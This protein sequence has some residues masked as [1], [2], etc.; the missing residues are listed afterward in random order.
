MALAAGDR[1]GPYEILAPLAVEGAGEVYRAHDTLRGREFAIKIS[2]ERF[3]EPFERQARAAA[4]LDHPHICAL[5]DVGPNY[6]VMEFVEGVPLRGPL[7]LQETLRF[8]TEIC[9]TLEYAQQRGILHGELKPSN[10][11]VT[12]PGIKILNFGLARAAPDSGDA[13]S[14]IYAAGCMLYEML[15]GRPIA[16]SRR[17][18]QPAALEKVLQK[19]LER[20]PAARYQSAG[21]LKQALAAV[22]HPK[23]FRSEYMVGAAS[24]VMLVAGLALLVMQF[25]SYQRL[26]DKD[27]LVLA[28]F[29]NATGDAIFDNT[30][31]T[32]LAIQLEQSPFLKI[33]DDDQM[34]QD[35]KRM[36][37]AP[38]TRISNALAHDICELERQKVMLN[39]AIADRGQAFVVTVQAV[40]CQNGATLAREQVQAE[41]RD[42]VL[43]AISKAATGIRA[44]LGEPPSSIEQRNQPLHLISAPSIETFAAYASGVAL[45]NQGRDLAA[46]SSLE[47]AIQLD[48]NFAIAYLQ[49]YF[50]YSDSGQNGPAENALMKAFAR[51]DHAS[52][53]ERLRIQAI[54]YRAATG[55]LSRA[56]A[57]NL[58]LSRIYPR[59]SLAHNQL[60]GI[61]TSLGEWE[62]ALAEY[63]A[64]SDPNLYSALILAYV[65]LDRFAEA[66]A[67]PRTPDLPAVHRALL[68]VAFMQPDLAA[69]A[70]EM[71]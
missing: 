50:A 22:S 13:R 6:L 60:G 26:S 46:I 47:H 8:A 29:S 36:S 43:N 41:G 33:L 11:L 49:L 12:Q 51:A 55:E 24:L 40:N 54:Y 1:L 53:F 68:R 20:D 25:P 69:A 57:S 59:S 67:I 14:D 3:S 7:S 10:I 2:P 23:G 35:L 5:Y 18:V 56:I 31:R 48:P 21:Q 16:E 65:R 32:A 63:Q 9:D 42:Q 34:Q 27:V 64:T 58:L 4:A 45:K 19:C 39:G 28:D 61:Y 71:T 15:M 44:K 38:D 17:P 66:K 70:T 30:L 62:K 52:E 37:R